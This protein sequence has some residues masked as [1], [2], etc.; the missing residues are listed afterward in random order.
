MREL[1]WSGL[2]VCIAVSRI[3]TKDS[4]FNSVTRRCEL[5]TE[6]DMLSSLVVRRI[7]HSAGKTSRQLCSLMLVLVMVG[8]ASSGTVRQIDRLETVSGNPR[9]LIMNPDVKYYLLTAGGVT[10]P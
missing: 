10:Q 5:D 6:Q 1:R 7:T 8:C 2:K 9:I 4:N 3:K